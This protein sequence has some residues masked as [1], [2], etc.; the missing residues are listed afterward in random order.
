MKEMFDGFDDV[1]WS[2]SCCFR[3]VG[4]ILVVGGR[5]SHFDRTWLTEAKGLSVY[6]RVDRRGGKEARA[7]SGE[8]GFVRNGDGSRFGST[9]VGYGLMIMFRTGQRSSF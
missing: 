1:C 7:A 9:T 4:W 3:D 6:I 2:W 8:L 5:L